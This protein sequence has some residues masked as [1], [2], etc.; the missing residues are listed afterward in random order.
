MEGFKNVPKDLIV[1]WEKYIEKVGYIHQ[2]T[3]IM[4]QDLRNSVENYKSD[5]SNR[6]NINTIPYGDW[7]GYNVM[8]SEFIIPSKTIVSTK[9][10][11]LDNLNERLNWLNL[12]SYAQCYE[13]FERFWKNSFKYIYKKNQEVELLKSCFNKNNRLFTNCDTFIAG[14]QFINENFASRVIQDCNIK[15]YFKL[16]STIR[17]DIVHNYGSVQTEV[18]NDLY[19][20]ILKKTAPKINEKYK[21]DSNELN[22]LVSSL[23]TISY[24][25]LSFFEYK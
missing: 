10:D 12:L 14:L 5:D 17:H 23:F 18:N 3:L 19:K 13:E 21:I 8:K 1:Y 7:V 4:I 6:V 11:Y 9:E 24:L 16:L 25:Y 2:Q 20:V 22:K 15:Q